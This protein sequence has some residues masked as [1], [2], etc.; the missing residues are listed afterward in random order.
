MSDMLLSYSVVH[1]LGLRSQVVHYRQV[2]L[3]A[4]YLL[5]GC[6]LVGCP[7]GDCLLAGCPLVD[8]LLT[9]RV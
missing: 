6:P 2:C 9:V 7:L 1:F 8:F 5:A 4:D 3:L